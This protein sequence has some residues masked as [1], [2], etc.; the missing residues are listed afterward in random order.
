MAV[1]GPAERVPAVWRPLVPGFELAGPTPGTHPCSAARPRSWSALPRRSRTG[2]NPG[3]NPVEFALA[4]PPRGV[5][6]LGAQVL[7]TG[8]ALTVKADANS[9]RRGYTANLIIEALC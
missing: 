4:N 3:S 6:L 9:T 8:V 2:C 5:R 7:P 1:T